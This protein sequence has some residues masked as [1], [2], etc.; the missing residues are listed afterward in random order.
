MVDER[1]I[2]SLISPKAIQLPI[3]GTREYLIHEIGILQAR[4]LS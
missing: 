2:K 3:A 1:D 4:S